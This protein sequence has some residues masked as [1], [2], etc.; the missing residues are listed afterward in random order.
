MRGQQEVQRLVVAA[1]L[2]LQRL[3]YAGDAIAVDLH[4]RRLHLEV[5][6]QERLRLKEWI[7]QANTEAPKGSLPVVVWRQS[8]GEWR[9]DLS[10]ST[11]LALLSE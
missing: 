11:L 4:G 5:K 7:E 10:L 1:G 2:D 9:A 3:A 8:R 6:R